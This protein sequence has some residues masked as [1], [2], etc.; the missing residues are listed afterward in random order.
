MD[1][2]ADWMSRLRW[3]RRS[4]VL[5]CRDVKITLFQVKVGH[6]KGKTKR[7]VVALVIEI[8]AITISMVA[9]DGCAERLS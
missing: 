1:G 6:D 8:V 2:L 9:Q 3:R 4:K 7:V 5:N